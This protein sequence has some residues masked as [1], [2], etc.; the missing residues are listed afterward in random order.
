MWQ[1]WI[2]TSL[3]DSLMILLS[4]VVI[5]IAVIVCVRIVGLRSLSKMSAFDFVITVAVGSL[6]GTSVVNP[7]PTMLM[8]LV[9]LIGLFAGQWLIAI[10]RLRTSINHAVDN[11]PVLLMAGS[12]ILHD[13][14]K[15]TNL[16]ENDLIA[17]L[18]EANV[19][20][21]RQVRAVVFE[22]TGDVSVLH[23]GNEA[24]EFDPR[25]LDNVDGAHRIDSAA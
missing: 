8:A 11:K 25:L 22:T 12:E 16:T 14:L 19:L 18:R 4:V 21:L 5:Y 6:V 10:L 9:A 23:S 15:R 1:E 7:T 3:Q 20:N 24:A 17:K 13:N 2:E